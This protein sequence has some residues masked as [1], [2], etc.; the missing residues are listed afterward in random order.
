MFFSFIKIIRNN[1]L[2]KRFALWGNEIEIS[3]QDDESSFDRNLNEVLYL[4]EK[5]GADIFVFEDMDRYNYNRIFEKLREVNQLLNNK[6]KLKGKTE[7]IRFFYL[8]RDDI[9][10]SKDRV[11][12]FD[13]IIP[14]VPVVDSSNSYDQFLKH[15][16]DAG[17]QDNFEQSFLSNLSL[18]VDD[19]R[20]LKNICNEY[21]IY[22][23]RISS[24]EQDKNKMLA[25]IVYKNLFPRDFAELQ[26][27]RGFVFELF[28]SKDKFRKNELERVNK[29]II[30]IEKKIENSSKE[31]TRTVQELDEYYQLKYSNNYQYQQN[32]NKIESEKNERKEAIKNRSEEQQEI[33]K[34]QI[35]KLGIEKSSISSRHLK[36]LITKENFDDIFKV[37]HTT[38]LS[39]E[40]NFG[41][42]KENHYFDLLKYLIRNGY[43]DETYSDYM[44]YFYPNSL[45]ERD[46]M[47]LRSITDQKAKEYHYE[48]NKPEL[49]FE[50]L[51]ITDFDQPETL[52]FALLSFLLNCDKAD[53]IKRL[54]EQVQKDNY[55]DFVSQF[56]T[57]EKD[58]EQF[59]RSLNQYCPAV[60][61]KFLKDQTIRDQQKHDYAVDTLL[62]SQSQDIEKINA[63]NCLENYIAHNSS[64]LNIENPH[65]EK[66]CTEL[67]LLDVKFI[68]IDYTNANKELFQAVYQ[69][70]LYVLNESNISLI[71]NEVYGTES[72]GVWHRSYTLIRSK[73]DEPL[74]KY[75]NE[76]IDAYFDLVM[77]LCESTIT[78][79]EPSAIEILN[80]ENIDIKKREQYIDF[81]QTEISSIKSIKD[82]KLWSVIFSRSIVCNSTENTLEYFFNS[83]KGLDNVLIEFVNAKPALKFDYEKIDEQFG[84]GKATA[85]LS[86]II[87]CNG[88]NNQKYKIIIKTLLKN[89]YYDKFLFDKIEPEK[90]KILLEL[91]FIKMTKENLLFMRTNYP[92]MVNEFILSA[93]VE[94]V[95]I[96][97]QETFNKDELLKL[98]E[99]SEFVNE[100]SVK[101]LSFVKEPISIQDKSYAD[102]VKVYILQNNFFAD[103]LDSLI[104]NYEKEKECV[105][106]EIVKQC[107]S[108]VSTIINKK[109]TLSL[110]LLL[111]LLA[112]MQSPVS[113]RIQVL[114]YHLS[115]MEAEQAKECFEALKM[116][117][118]ASLFDGKKPRI[119]NIQFAEDILKIL[120]D[121]KWVSS[122]KL[123]DTPDGDGKIYFRVIGKIHK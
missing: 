24:T 67:A 19:M 42:V 40:T 15:F 89:K 111:S 10:T 81:L 93:P 74:L 66:I 5:A 48:L 64:F 28:V 99:I 47:F 88:I 107:S 79:D 87:K 71:L 37:I 49:I 14:I 3:R 73:Q 62:Y 58:I 84:E 103:D 30:A 27:R 101:L 9:F 36:A 85:F 92:D 60:C 102:T 13:Y 104:E 8:L 45:T 38:E 121:K 23:A 35:A 83:G 22:D 69:R 33:L 109:I 2:F 72:T 17:I 76:N 108:S 117:D 98:L 32:R 77:K 116:D 91:G 63:G 106:K 61:L 31:W 75:V 20:I 39:K 65:I 18:Y 54:M 122:Y 53:E 112:D 94:Y 119:E 55:L 6:R 50:R 110:H 16:A 25:M 105:Q 90:I 68:Q 34:V 86:A 26:L 59:V 41:D 118:Y 11:K 97:T 43:I 46:K 52:N 114:L 56:L 12:F 120:Q 113:N 82:K 29:E 4:F 95:S 80:N 78:D 1:C 96:V 115:E 70:D 57:R 51:Q 7:P 100:N 123:E 44:T 21:L